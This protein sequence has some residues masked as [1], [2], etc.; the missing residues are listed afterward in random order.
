M[1][2]EEAPTE[3]ELGKPQ[4]VQTPGSSPPKRAE[5]LEASS[6]P[7]ES[8]GK[9]AFSAQDPSQSSLVERLSGIF[10]PASFKHFLMVRSTDSMAL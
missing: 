1:D 2:G 4:E 3:S 5:D 6:S 10:E 7:F 9:A 8:Q